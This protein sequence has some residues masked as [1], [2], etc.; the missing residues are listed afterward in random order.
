[1]EI[2]VEDRVFFLPIPVL[3]IFHNK[4][5]MSS[6]P[7]SRF[8]QLNTDLEE[9]YGKTTPESYEKLSQAK[10]DA[11]CADIRKEMKDIISS[12]ALKL[13]KL[14]PYRMKAFE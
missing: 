7:L 13:A 14:L 9:C 8:V 12:D 6:N 3:V 2:P 4:I 10:K 11:L 1:M 5:K